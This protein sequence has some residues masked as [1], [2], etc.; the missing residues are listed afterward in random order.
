[1]KE[2]IKQKLI[3]YFQFPKEI[4]QLVYFSLF[5]KILM[6]IGIITRWSSYTQILISLVLDTIIFFEIISHY[7]D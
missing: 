4:R 2:K 5:Y 3:S 7:R 6:V 1:M